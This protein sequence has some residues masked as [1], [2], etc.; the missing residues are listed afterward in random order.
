MFTPV[1]TRAASAY[2]R[3]SV[4]TS[5]D[6]ASP[7][8]LVNLLFDA[9]LQSMSLARAALERGDLA[10]KGAQLSKAVRLIEEGLKAA[11]DDAG[12]EVA[13]NLRTVYSYAVRCLTEANLKNDVDKIG[14][15][16]GLIEPIAD[17]WKQIGK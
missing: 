15:V 3:V 8:E 6:G 10:L 1:S 12:G 13:G 2:K 11:L 4:E 16:I 9:L 17:A 14:E 7:H 5:V